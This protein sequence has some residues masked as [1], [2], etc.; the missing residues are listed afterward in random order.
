M[1]DYV[2]GGAPTGPG[3]GPMHEGTKYGTDVPQ[4]THEMLERAIELPSIPERSETMFRMSL[5]ARVLGWEVLG[6]QQLR[7]GPPLDLTLTDSVT[8]LL[9]TL[10]EQVPAL[11]PSASTGRRPAVGG[12]NSIDVP[13]VVFGNCT[14]GIVDFLVTMPCS[15]RWMGEIRWVS[16]S[17]GARIRSPRHI[18]FT[19]QPSLECY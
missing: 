14:D 8:L 4:V 9:R 18:K 3:T 12:S 11:H 16:R 19:V 17:S 15:G 1:R 10:P 2:G 6:Q 13:G 7:P 5:G